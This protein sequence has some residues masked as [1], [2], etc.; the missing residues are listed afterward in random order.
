MAPV[1]G[2][3]LAFACYMTEIDTTPAGFR[4]HS[5]VL[6]LRERIP[7]G[8][9]RPMEWLARNLPLARLSAEYRNEALIN[10]RTAKREQQSQAALT[11]SEPGPADPIPR[12]VQCYCIFRAVGENHLIASYTD[13]LNSD[14]VPLPIYRRDNLDVCRFTLQALFRLNEARLKV[15]RVTVTP[16]LAKNELDKTARGDGCFGHTRTDASTAK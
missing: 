12:F 1:R 4:G 13:L 8:I 16:Q 11:S 7:E 3:T 6:V 5:G 15:Y 2:R 9:A 14:G 10:E